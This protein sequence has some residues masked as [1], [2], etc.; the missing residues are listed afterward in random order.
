MNYASAVT[1][2]VV[3]LA[4]AWFFIGGRKHYRVSVPLTPPLS[5]RRLG[6]ELT[7][8]TCGQGPRNVLAEEKTQKMA[9]TGDDLDEIKVPA[10]PGAL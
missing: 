2:G 1:C 8:L 3:L 9:P 7:L 6:A 10:G 4:T 5:P